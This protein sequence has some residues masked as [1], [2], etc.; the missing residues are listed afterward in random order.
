M[1]HND[2]SDL[3]AMS[4]SDCDSKVTNLLKIN[5]NTST[6]DRCM[7]P[8]PCIDKDCGRN[9]KNKFNEEER[10]KIHNLYWGMS[11]QGQRKWLLSCVKQI[12]IKSRRKRGPS[13]RTCSYDYFLPNIINGQ[14]KVCQKFILKTLDISQ[15]GLYSVLF[16]GK[17]N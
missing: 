6:N 13:R 7:Q 12:D 15:K 2:F 17:H 9:C 3:S 5:Y 11:K 16:D 1:T 4:L 10:Q 14:V 8:N